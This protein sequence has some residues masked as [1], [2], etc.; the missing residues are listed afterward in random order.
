MGRQSSPHRWRRNFLTFRNKKMAT[1]L[2]L[3]RPNAR[4]TTFVQK[5]GIRC[6]IS[7]FMLGRSWRLLLIL[8]KFVEKASFTRSVEIPSALHLGLLNLDKKLDVAA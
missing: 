4:L 1:K 7:L 6:L 2:R 3:M 8:D 5:I